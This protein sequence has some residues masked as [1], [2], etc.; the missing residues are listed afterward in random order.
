[1]DH[2]VQSIGTYASLRQ[3]ESKKNHPSPG[4]VLVQEIKSL[5]ST[6]PHQMIIMS[7]TLNAP[8]KREIRKENWMK[9]P[10]LVNCGQ[11]SL[12]ST[13]SHHLFFSGDIGEAEEQLIEIVKK[14]VE[15][16]ENF[17][18]ILFIDSMASV[19]DQVARLTALGMNSVD[20]SSALSFDNPGKTKKT[21]ENFVN[22]KG[23]RLFVT[24][25]FTARGFDIPNMD[26]VFILGCFFKPQ[27]YIHMAGRTARM[28]NKGQVIT[29][30]PPEKLKKIHSI[31]KYLDIEF[32]SNLRDEIERIQA[33]VDAEEEAQKEQENNS[34]ENEGE[35]GDEE[36][37][38]FEDS[39]PDYHT[40]KNSHQLE[41]PSNTKPN[42][43]KAKQ[44][45][46]TKQHTNIGNKT[47][48]SR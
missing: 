40:K 29:I 37:W 26:T 14:E 35:E 9:T 48:F 33:E 2:I 25:E 7:A 34:Q 10:V 24:T 5:I 18:A 19:R 36:E 39:S 28:G 12:P 47:K 1:V 21:F 16:N 20:L 43:L 8:T 45:S 46:P 4:V 32:P 42:A 6:H 41:R 22:G 27:S 38:K 13:L 31:F 44:L 15:K 17:R 30:L 11:V 23:I 3:K